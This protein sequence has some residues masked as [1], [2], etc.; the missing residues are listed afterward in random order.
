MVERGTSRSDAPGVTRAGILAFGLALWVIAIAGYVPFDQRLEIARAVYVGLGATLPL[1]LRLHIVS[2]R[3]LSWIVLP[4]VA[5]AALWLWRRGPD[6]L[7]AAKLVSAT[8][9]VAFVW[10]VVGL[11]LGLHATMFAVI[12]ELR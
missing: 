6:G 1:P 7:G 5:M 10:T 12:G 3:T 2:A 4:L 8:G 11:I 9:L